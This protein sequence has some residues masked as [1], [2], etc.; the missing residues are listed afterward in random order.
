MTEDAEFYRSYQLMEILGCASIPELYRR[1]GPAPNY[2]S[3]L[4]YLER[5]DELE[6]ERLRAI[7]GGNS[8]E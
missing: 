8:A 1:V 5:R 2:V 7:M 3:W 4:V 6:Q